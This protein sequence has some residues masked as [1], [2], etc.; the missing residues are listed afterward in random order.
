MGRMGPFR[1]AHGN[2]DV[3]RGLGCL[4]STFS[5]QMRLRPSLCLLAPGQPNPSDASGSSTLI[6]SPPPRHRSDTSAPW[7][8]S[9][10]TA[11]PP[12][13]WPKNRVF[14]HGQKP[15][16]NAQGWLETDRNISSLDE[17]KLHQGPPLRAATP[18]LAGGGLLC[19]APPLPRAV[20]SE[21]RRGL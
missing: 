16:K 4:V 11:L 5:K 20:L 13:R 7:V 14:A 9:V 10:T 21:G 12:Q 8:G 17:L 19:F 18:S 6:S 2:P 3:P 15:A 1:L